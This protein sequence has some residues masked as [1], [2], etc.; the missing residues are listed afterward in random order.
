MNKLIKSLLVVAGVALTGSA[1]AV[2]SSEAYCAG[3]N[4]R[5][6]SG[7]EAQGHTE[8]AR[9]YSVRGIYLIGGEQGANQVKNNPQLVKAYQDGQA[10]L[11][12]YVRVKDL[13]AAS[14]LVNNLCV[15]K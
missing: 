9:K 11:D 1:S 2:N 10:T 3:V 5:F 14:N 8:L 7:L 6:S 4:F 12:S 13:K 15:P